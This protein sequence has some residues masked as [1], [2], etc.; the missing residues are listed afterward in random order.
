MAFTRSDRGEWILSSDGNHKK[1]ISNS[2][3]LKLWVSS[4]CVRPWFLPWHRHSSW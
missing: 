4:N 1:I 3:K 2:K